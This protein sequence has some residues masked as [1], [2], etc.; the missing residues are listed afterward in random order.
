MARDEL[1]DERLN[2]GMNAQGQ[3]GVGGSPSRPTEKEADAATRRDEEQA[4][5]QRNKRYPTEDA[6]SQVAQ[7]GPQATPE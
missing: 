6:V 1:E 3:N 5:T 7:K 4:G 2:P